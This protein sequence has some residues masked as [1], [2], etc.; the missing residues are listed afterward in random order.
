MEMDVEPETGACYSEDSFAL[1]DVTPEI[2]ECEDE[3]PLVQ[4]DTT[5]RTPSARPNV[6]VEIPSVSPNK[7]R[8]APSIAQ[9][10]Q[11][12]GI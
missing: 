8:R 2:S 7:R 10:S 1:E 5:L 3:L 12:S 11:G 9:P 4:K 6:A